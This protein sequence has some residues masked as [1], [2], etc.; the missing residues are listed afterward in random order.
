MGFHVHTSVM[1]Q[2]QWQKYGKLLRVALN[3]AVKSR[4]CAQVSH[5]EQV[6]LDTNRASTLMYHTDETVSCLRVKAHKGV[7]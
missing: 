3:S 4:F 5:K 6:T 1:S 2:R 7:Q